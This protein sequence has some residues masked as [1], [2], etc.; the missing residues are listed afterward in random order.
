MSWEL[1]NQA[2]VITIPNVKVN[3]LRINS[4]NLA[5]GFQ[6]TVYSGTYLGY[7]A[8]NKIWY[9]FL[10]QSFFKMWKN[11]KIHFYIKTHMVIW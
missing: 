8:K 9:L 2:N 11:L 5:Y 10:K 1:N 7:K 6:A 3:R 4:E